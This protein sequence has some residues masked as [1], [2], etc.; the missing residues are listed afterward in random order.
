MANLSLGNPISIRVCR[1]SGNMSGS[2]GVLT[3][4]PAGVLTLQAG[5]GIAGGTTSLG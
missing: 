2:A 3:L 1:C 5:S 4:F